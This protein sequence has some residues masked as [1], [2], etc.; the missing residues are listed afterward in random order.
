MRLSDLLEHE[1]VT[2][3][4]RRVG[5]VHDV[6]LVQDGP[7]LGVWGHALRLD[8]LLVGGGSM[9]GRVGLHR[10]GAH[11][12]WLLRTVLRLL[13]REP[14]VVPWDGVVEVGERVVVRRQPG[15]GA[16]GGGSAAGSGFA[17]GR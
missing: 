1:V 6:R 3:D 11:G 8:A 17:G 7:M 5:R 9:L 2:D 12:P 10:H 4:G 13:V 16:D 15:G 14:V